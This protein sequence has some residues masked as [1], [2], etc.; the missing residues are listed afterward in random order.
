MRLR[1]SASKASSAEY[2]I[3]ATSLAVPSR[4]AMSSRSPIDF[5]EAS[6]VRS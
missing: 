2:G 1:L 6:S 4:S 5:A 3:G